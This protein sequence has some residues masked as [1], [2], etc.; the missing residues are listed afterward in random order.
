MVFRVVIDRGI[1]ANKPPSRISKKAKPPAESDPST[2]NQKHDRILMPIVE[3]FPVVLEGQGRGGRGRN[4][5]SPNA[6]TLFH[7]KF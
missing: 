6:T 4:P 5:P 1:T 7:R 3:P 2:T